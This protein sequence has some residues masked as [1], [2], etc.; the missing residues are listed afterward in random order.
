MPMNEATVLANTVSAYCTTLSGIWGLMLCYTMGMQPRRWLFAYF[1]L[2]V[3]GLA[4]IWMHGFGEE[5]IPRIAD[6]G[7]NLLLAWAI[8][9]G[10]LGDYYSK[11]TLKAVAGITGVVNLA[12]IIL[13]SAAGASRDGTMAMTFGN[14]GGFSFGEALLILNSILATVLWYIKHAQIPRQARPLLYIMTFV[15]LV[16]AGLATAGNHTLH[17]KIM[18]YHATWHTVGAY[19][20]IVLW[21]FN[22]VRFV[23][24]GQKA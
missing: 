11:R 15:F 16:G 2:F 13:R 20:F 22:H 14:F 17:F 7:T 19:G 8:Q 12:Y 3:T 18:A 23:H 1:C 10:I 4:T 6:I 9:V 21:A 5:L 24:C